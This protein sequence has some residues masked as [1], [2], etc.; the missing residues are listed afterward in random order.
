MLF[1]HSSILSIVPLRTRLKMDAFLIG[2]QP[3]I[4]QMN[5]PFHDLLCFGFNRPRGTCLNYVSRFP[6]LKA[7]LLSY[8]PRP[9]SAE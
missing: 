7:W 3:R 1:H 5:P 8:R 9:A 4:G 6:A 2:S